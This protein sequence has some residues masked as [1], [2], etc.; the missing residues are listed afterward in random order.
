MAN[1]IP[2]RWQSRFDFFSAY[3]H[4]GSTPEARTAFKGLPF[5]KRFRL[6]FNFPPFI[7]GPLY[8][9]VMGMWRKGLAFLGLSIAIGIAAFPFD[10]PGSLNTGIA[11]GIGL[12]WSTAANYA[13][14]L[15]VTEHSTSWNPWEGQ[16]KQKTT[17]QY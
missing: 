6:I 16:G 17:A 7:F 2:P 15:H 14:Y 8:F 11:T 10:I 4:Q 13:Y 3:G 12:M 1:S 5:G 9:F